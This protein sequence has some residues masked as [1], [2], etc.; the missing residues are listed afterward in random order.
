MPGGDGDAAP[1]EAVRFEHLPVDLVHD[2]VA[3]PHRVD[4]RAGDDDHEDRRVR[5]PAHRLAERR[6]SATSERRRDDH[7]DDDHEQQDR[8]RCRCRVRHDVD[9]GRRGRDGVAR[10]VDPPA[11]GVD[12]AVPGGHA[13]HRRAGGQDGDHADE[14]E[15]PGSWPEPAPLGRHHRSGQDRLRLPH[16]VTVAPREARGGGGPRLPS[17]AGDD[18]SSGDRPGLSAGGARPPR[19]RSS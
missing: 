6:T 15:P 1:R 2:D 8:E 7:A 17:G 13:P 12:P 18:R 19:R 16:G 14:H 4:Q 11:V 5:P 9:G 10:A 3:L